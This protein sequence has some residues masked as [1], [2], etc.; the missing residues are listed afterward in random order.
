MAFN[1]QVKFK[2]DLNL[3]RDLACEYSRLSSLPA[4]TGVRARELSRANAPSGRMR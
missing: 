3:W 4:A 1:K 2:V